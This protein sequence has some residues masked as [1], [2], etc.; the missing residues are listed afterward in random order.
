MVLEQLDIY[1]KKINLDKSSAPFT[2][3]NPKYII[4]LNVKHK[5]TRF[6]EDNRKK[7]DD[8]GMM[9]IFRYKTKDMMNER[10]S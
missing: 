1:M 3:I 7:L 5:A 2:K 9:I 8:L 4:D 6:L 10:N